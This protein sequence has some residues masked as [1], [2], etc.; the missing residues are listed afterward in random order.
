MD[1]I[2]KLKNTST[3]WL[4]DAGLETAMIFLEGI[5]LPHFAAFTMLDSEKGRNALTRYFDEFLQ[6]AR[7]L[8]TGFV[9]DTPTWRAGTVWGAE[10]GLNTD[11]IQAVNRDSVAF[12]QTLRETWETPQLPI[13]LNGVVG[14]AGDGYAPENVLTPQVARAIHDAQVAALV[15][16]GVDMIS[17]VTMTHSGEAIGI[18]RAAAEHGCRS[19]VAFTV[20]TDGRLPTGQTIGDAIGEVDDATGNS[21]LFYM[22]NCAHPDHFRDALTRGAPWLARIGAVRANASRM[23]HAELDQAEE[24]DFGDPAELA[25]DYRVLQQMLGQLKVLGGCCGTDHRHIAAIGQSCVHAHA[26]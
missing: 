2:E 20:E 26:A 10:L 15:D 14:P 9:L 16:A 22:I 13:I 21:P 7:T 25:G 18:V 4:T 11:Q 23:S 19:V 17:A 12:L 8:G 1:R 3:P 6:T 5:D 24:L